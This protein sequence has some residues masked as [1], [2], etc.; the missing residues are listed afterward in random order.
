MARAQRDRFDVVAI[1]V[2]AT[3][4]ASLAATLGFVVSLNT[5]LC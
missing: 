1:A 3:Y 2:S 5:I 4:H